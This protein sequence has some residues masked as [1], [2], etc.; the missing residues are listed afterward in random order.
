MGG[1]SKDSSVR[2]QTTQQNS[3]RRNSQES[4]IT[5]STGG[6]FTGRSAGNESET[7]D[8]VLLNGEWAEFFDES[9]EANYW[10]NNTTGEASWINPFS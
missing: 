8:H 2:T 3:T 5:Q 9:A 1:S 6:F 7:I 10:F 4:S